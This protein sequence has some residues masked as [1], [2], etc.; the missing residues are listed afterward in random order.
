MA[1]ALFAQFL[2]GFSIVAILLIISL[3]LA[4]IFGVM[5]VIN[6]AH[7]DFIMVGA[8]V[9]FVMQEYFKLNLFWGIPAAFLVLAGIGMTGEWGLIRQLYGRPLETLLA[10]WGVSVV[11]QQGIRLIFGP[12]LR[13]VRAPQLLD[14]DFAVPGSNLPFPYFRLFIIVLALGLLLLTY[15]I[16]YRT[17]V[18]MRVRAV[19]QNR[20]MAEVLGI[21]T[22]RID[23]FVFA[24]GSGLAGV[25]GTI[26]APIKTVSP[27]MGFPYAVDSY[28]VIV[29]GGVGRLVGTV[30]GASVIGE[31]ET[32]LAFLYNNVIAKL[33]VFTLIVLVIRVFP[34]GLFT[35]QR[36]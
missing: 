20:P 36:R 28:M 1:E 22:R 7:G 27:G 2:T 15:W 19:N 13:Y 17:D 29:L 6:M 3:G 21:D 34:Q 25:A 23:R 30:A 4:V 12:E 5:R 9:A 10:T 18:G 8:Y 31:S 24:F 11:L 26:L 35:L 33:L 32:V 16:L 14:G